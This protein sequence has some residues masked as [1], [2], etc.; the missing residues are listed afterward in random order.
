MVLP[1]LYL[2]HTLDDTIT[3]WGGVQADPLQLLWSVSFSKSCLK[4]FSQTLQLGPFSGRV[5]GLGKLFPRVTLVKK[6]VQNNLWVSTTAQT[7][8]APVD[9]S[10]QYTCSSAVRVWLTRMNCLS[11][12]LPSHSSLLCWVSE[13]GA[14]SLSPCMASSLLYLLQFSLPSRP[15]LPL[16][17][18]DCKV[19]QAAHPLA[20]VQMGF[21]GSRPKNVTKS[22]WR[23][24]LWQVAGYGHTAVNPLAVGRIKLLADR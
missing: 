2:R 7:H 16:A 17:A 21:C 8:P 20:P 11:L 13:N 5:W 9:I 23:Q 18:A 15:S 3:Y 24:W 14:H 4:F 22:V 19:V 10:F 1:G 12:P 6:K